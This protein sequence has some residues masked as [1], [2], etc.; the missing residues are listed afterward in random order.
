MNEAAAWDRVKRNMN[1]AAASERGKRLSTDSE[2]MS[3]ARCSPKAEESTQQLK[4]RPTACH[5]Q[6]RSAACPTPAHS[7]QAEQCKVRPNPTTRNQDIP[8]AAATEAV[9]LDQEADAA[10]S[11]PER[12]KP[13]GPGVRSITTTKSKAIG[14]L[15]RHWQCSTR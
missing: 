6:T 12:S 2:I 13:A 9:P 5:Y 11:E 1:E 10:A 8:V 3:Q 14:T 15:L 4:S 7:M